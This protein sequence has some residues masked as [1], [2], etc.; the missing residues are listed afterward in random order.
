MPW[1]KSERYPPGSPAM[2]SSHKIDSVT[3]LRLSSRCT[4]ACPAR[5]GAAGPAGY[6]CRPLQRAGLPAPVTSSGNGQLSP[7]ASNRRIVNRTVEGAVVHALPLYRQNP[8]PDLQRSACRQTHNGFRRTL[9][10]RS[11]H[12]LSKAEPQG[13]PAAPSEGVKTKPICWVRP[14][15]GDNRASRLWYVLSKNE[16]HASQEQGL[17]AG[18]RRVGDRKSR[19]SG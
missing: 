2:Y 9:E 16:H 7:D 3:C 8:A 15:S 14:K 5:R 1:S 11:S 4:A 17:S 12:G 18:W 13:A 10:N 6:R 19:R